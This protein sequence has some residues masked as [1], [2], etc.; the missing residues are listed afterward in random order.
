MFLGT[1]GEEPETGGVGWIRWQWHT[2][3]FI[4]SFQNLPAPSF[5][6]GHALP[7]IDG[8]LSE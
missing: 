3:D 4:P 5:P 2:Q 6:F 1:E 8:M 7:K